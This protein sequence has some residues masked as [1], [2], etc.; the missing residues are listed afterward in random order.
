MTGPLVRLDGLSLS[1]LLVQQNAVL[2]EITDRLIQ[3]I[4]SAAQVRLHS[5]VNNK[6]RSSFLVIIHR[7]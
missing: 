3:M 5:S 2:I 6:C 4:Y 1:V 7:V